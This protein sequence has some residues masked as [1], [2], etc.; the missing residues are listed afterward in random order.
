M[1]EFCDR[2][3]EQVGEFIV[4]RNIVGSC[5]KSVAKPSKETK[6]SCDGREPPH[7]AVLSYEADV[8]IWERL[9]AL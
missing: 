7:S 9:Q 2:F 1:V 8:T 4:S 6:M 5:N 3:N